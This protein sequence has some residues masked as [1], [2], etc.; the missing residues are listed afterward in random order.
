MTYAD[1]VPAG[2]DASFYDELGPGYYLSPEKLEGDYATVR[3]RREL[4]ILRRFCA[5]G[6]V[7]DV[8]CSTGA[9]LYQVEKHFPDAY[10]RTGLEVSSAAVRHARSRGIDVIEDSL[11]THEF[12]DRRF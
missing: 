6:S 2:M 8:G 5:R 4:G 7:L 3:F 11:V 10:C 9:F 1:P 12:G